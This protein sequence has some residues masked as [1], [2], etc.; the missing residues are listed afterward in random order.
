MSTASEDLKFLATRLEGIV[1]L[2]P[3][4]ERTES[5]DNHKKELESQVI[6]LRKKADSLV[7]ETKTKQ[8]ELDTWTAKVKI[9]EDSFN[10]HE[11]KLND[12]KSS[13]SDIK[14]KL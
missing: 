1:S 14:S 12:L 8:E 10:E 9:L 3:L 6:K 11:T 5:L 4:L 7:E 13:L 2:V